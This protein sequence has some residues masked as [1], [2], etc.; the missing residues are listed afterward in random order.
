MRT[1]ILLISLILVISMESVRAGGYLEIGVG[2]DDQFQA[3]SNIEGGTVPLGRFT[4]GYEADHDWMIEIE[5][6][7]SISNTQ[8]Q[9]INTFWVTKR[10]NLF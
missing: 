2:A 5:H 3:E 6:R 7:S 9:G 8:D 4:L 10:I 1:I